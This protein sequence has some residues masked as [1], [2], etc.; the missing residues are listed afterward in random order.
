VNTVTASFNT[1]MGQMVEISQW[2]KRGLHVNHI[3][4][5]LCGHKLWHAIRQSYH[6]NLAV[7]I[8]STSSKSYAGAIL[9]FK[10]YAALSTYKVEF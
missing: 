3:G 7:S 8:Y 10:P 9:L 1:I 5:V 4:T 6:L 2:K